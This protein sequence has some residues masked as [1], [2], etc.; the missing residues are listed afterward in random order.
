ML[1]LRIGMRDRES[2][3]AAGISSSCL[4]LAQRE[5][6]SYGRFYAYAVKRTS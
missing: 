4:V 5:M 1:T 3:R 6:C 2:V